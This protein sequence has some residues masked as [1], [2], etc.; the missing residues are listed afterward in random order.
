MLRNIWHWW[1]FR[2]GCPTKVE[3]A[4]CC[5]RCFI[6]VLYQR[7]HH[8]ATRMTMIKASN[9]LNQYNCNYHCARISCILYDFFILICPYLSVCI[10]I[11]RLWRTCT[12]INNS[13][14]FELFL[15]LPFIVISTMNRTSWWHNV[16]K[17]IAIKSRWFTNP[18]LTWIMFCQLNSAFMSDQDAN[19]QCWWYIMLPC[20]TV[21]EF[22]EL[23]KIH[24]I[25]IGN[26]DKFIIDSF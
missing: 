21:C 20:P 3:P 16:F 23:M 1:F 24:T 2:Y 18:L 5:L 9:V 13:H 12:Q 8:H 4:C 19:L 6:G 7:L 14:N 25:N 17:H 15:Y 10:R 22:E 11:I 26:L